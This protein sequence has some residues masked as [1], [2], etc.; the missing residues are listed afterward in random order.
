MSIPADADIVLLDD[1]HTGLPFDLNFSKTFRGE[2]LTG[3]LVKVSSINKILDGLKKT[4]IEIDQSMMLLFRF[5]LVNGYHLNKAMVKSAFL[6]LHPE[7]IDK[8]PE[9]M[10]D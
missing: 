5:N 7:N 10:K 2:Y 3:Y 1:S 8:T 9:S 4:D 6:S